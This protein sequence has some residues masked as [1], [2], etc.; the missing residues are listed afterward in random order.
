MAEGRAHASA[1]NLPGSCHQVEKQWRERW[2][3]VVAQ[4]QAELLAFLIIQF[5]DNLDRRSLDPGCRMYY[6]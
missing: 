2:T 3:Y 1:I 4:K 6:I 5:T